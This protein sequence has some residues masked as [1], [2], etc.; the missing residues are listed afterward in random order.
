MSQAVYQKRFTEQQYLELERK[1]EYKR[2]YYN[3]KI[4]AIAGAS[5]RHNQITFN[6][7][8]ELRNQLRG[9]P[10][11]AFVN[12]MRIKV[13]ETG[14]YAYPDV[15]ASSGE[16]RFEDTYADTLLN[17]EIIIEVLSDSTEAFDRGEKFAHYRKIPTLAD[18]LLVSQKFCRVDHSVYENK[19]WIL[20]EYTDL[21]DKITL[22]SIGCYLLLSEIYD[23]VNF[24]EKG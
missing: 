7:A 9:R 18:Y 5:R 4:Y 14:L 10:C 3:G 23:K 22:A 1:A 17:P 16:P 11:F 8:G 20:Q 21:N 12:D 6:I 15:V 13:R 19:R 24:S 2:E